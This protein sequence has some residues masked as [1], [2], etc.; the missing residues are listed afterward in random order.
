[1]NLQCFVNALQIS[2]TVKNHPFLLY[3]YQKS[4]KKIQEA[5]YYNKFSRYTPSP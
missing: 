1:M 4:K 3:N 2:K 5:L